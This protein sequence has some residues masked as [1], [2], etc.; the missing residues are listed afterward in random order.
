M[1][2]PMKTSDGKDSPYFGW[3]IADRKGD[4]LLTHGGAQQGT[5]TY[6]LMVPAKG[7]AVAVIANTE[8]VNM[9]ELARQ[10][11]DILLP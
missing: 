3:T 1:Q 10:V 2:S 11:A 4:K 5:A 9:G 6:L 8:D 7:F